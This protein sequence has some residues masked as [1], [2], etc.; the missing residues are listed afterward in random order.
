MKK[1]LFGALLLSSF[2]AFAA[3]KCTVQGYTSIILDNGYVL[4]DVLISD[5]KFVT[6]TK[7][8]NDCY[9]YALNKAKENPATIL[10]TVSQ[11]DLAIDTQSYIYFEWTYNDSSIPFLDSAGKLTQYT[12][13]FESSPTDGDLRY[14]SDGRV[15]N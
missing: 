8:M 9:S 3:E 10:L 2:T 5:L 7:S 11:G 14:F 4:R 1:L 13:K 12:D 6:R 15:F